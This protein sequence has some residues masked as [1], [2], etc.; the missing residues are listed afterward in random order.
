MQQFHGYTPPSWTRRQFLSRGGSLAVAASAGGLSALL[1]ACAPDGEEAL[2]TATLPGQ[3]FT[4]SLSV[5]IGTHMDPI[6]ELIA[7][8]PARTGVT[9]KVEEI[10]TPDLSTK[11]RTSFLAQQSPWDSVFILAEN[12][13]EL[14][15][16]DWLVDASA[17][18]DEKVRSQGDLLERGMG[19]VES[20]G[21]TWAVPW[22]MGSQLLQWNTKLVEDAGLDPDAPLTWHETPN[23][24]DTFVE[25]AKAMTGER[26][27]VPHYGYTDAW[28]GTHILWT[29]GG[30]LQMHGGS[31]LD[32]EQ[33]PAWNSDAGVA[34]TEKLYELLR[35]HQIIDPA[36]LTYTWVFDASPGFLEGTRG[37]II[38]WPFMAGIAAGPDSGIAGHSAFAPNPAVDTSGSVDGSEFFAV[39][40]FAE[41]SDEAWRFLEL[42]TS[43]EGQR[44]VAMG[45]WG[46]IYSEILKEPEIVEAFPFYPAIAQAYQYPVDGG[47]SADRPRWTQ[48]LSD[49]LHE[50]LN[51]SKTAKEALDDAARLVVE[52]R[53]EEQ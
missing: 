17:F 52:A 49:Q 9:P 7:G 36:V 51:D 13:A 28:A 30:V 24:W 48:I 22:T 27:G 14:A 35:V 8:Y 10:T 41:N 12:A 29:W 16:R 34:A 25:Y 44:T 47:W 11:L 43:P 33:Q 23:S 50:V 37:M 40:V 19:A 42:V 3:D 1:A 2:P 46:S 20:R 32:E 15:G 45:G 38:T 5:L 31:F 4:G 26:D 6:K 53:K 21:A 39:P 18:M